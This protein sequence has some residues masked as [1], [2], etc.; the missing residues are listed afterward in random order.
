MPSW[1]L[2]AYA[3]G[4]QPVGIGRVSESTGGTVGGEIMGWKEDWKVWMSLKLGPV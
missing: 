3:Y 1:K 4:S 2:F